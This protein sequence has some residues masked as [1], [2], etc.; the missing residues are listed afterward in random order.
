MAD[1]ITRAGWGATYD[2]Y[3]SNG[4]Y[5]GPW[6]ECVIHT[7]GAIYRGSTLAS[8]IAQVRGQER[9]HVETR[10]WRGIAYSFLISPA[11]RIFEGRGWLRYGAHT[12][13]RNGSAHGIQ[14]MG[15]GDIDKATEAQWSSA[16][17]LITEGI[18][19]RTITASPKISGHRNYSQKGKSCPG[20]LIYAELDRLRNLERPDSV[21]EKP[22]PPQEHDDMV[23]IATDPAGNVHACFT[24][25]RERIYLRTTEEVEIYQRVEGKSVVMMP[26]RVSWNWLGQ[27]NQVRWDRSNEHNH[28]DVYAKSYAAV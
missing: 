22:S 27:F 3:L 23:I 7:A 18:R 20:D 14:F 17:W 25:T 8:D 9:F 4:L 13:T 11:G 6:G 2:G 19:L 5:K 15:H 10:G 21:P 16:R 28:D 24:G 1:I 12:E 26:A